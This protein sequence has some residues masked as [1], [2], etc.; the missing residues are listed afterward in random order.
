MNTNILDE[1]IIDGQLVVKYYDE[2]L[3]DIITFEL[4][5]TDPVKH[6]SKISFTIYMIET[7]NEQFL[8]K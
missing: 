7:T 5:T 4:P 3:D 1:S 8:V 6:I 2:Q